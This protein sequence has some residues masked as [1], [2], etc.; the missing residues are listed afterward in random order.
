M[1]RKCM[2]FGAVALILL[3]AGGM[4]L[5]GPLGFSAD[6]GLE[7]TYTPVPPASFDI[8]SDLSL[9]FDIAGFSLVSETGFNLIGFQSQRVSIGVDLGAVQIAE[10][11]RF[12]PLFSWNQLSLDLSI[13][14][15]S[16]GMDWILADIGVPPTPAYSMGSV[17]ELSSGIVCGFTIASLTGFGATDL[18]SLLDG[19]EA[20]YSDALLYLF[21]HVS[22]LCEGPQDLDVTIVP[23]FYFEEELVRMEVDLMGMIAS[24]TTWFDA[25]GLS[26]MLFELGFRFDEPV[27]SFLSTITLDGAFAITEMN[28]ILDL[29]IDV[30]RF[31]SHTQFAA[32]APPSLLPIVFSG[33]G[34]A[35]SFEF[36]G[37]TVT[38]LTEFDGTFL[39]AQEQIAIEADIAPVHFISLTTFDIAGFAG[40]CIYADVVFCGVTLYTRIDF[41]F[42]GIQLASFGFD[43][44]F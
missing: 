28:L 40:Q 7:V 13:V 43:L 25:M 3:S 12:E 41:D 18:V 39:F 42:S 23:G 19:V 5:G 44:T 38:S 30:V 26:K 24:S 22:G 9:G 35:V 1:L 11:M 8:G 21:H 37:V 33:Q 34:F 16:I 6:V 2:Q 17:L 32:S 31:T 29:Q 15:V 20:P 10:Q 27:F 36:C 4:A 14:G